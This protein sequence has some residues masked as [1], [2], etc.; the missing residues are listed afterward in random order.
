MSEKLLTTE[1][2]EKLIIQRS[3]HKKNKEF[4]K[5]DDIREFL[6]D[7]YVYVHDFEGKTTW[8]LDIP[9]ETKPL[10]PSSSPSFE[11]DWNFYSAN[12][13]N[14][15][16][17]GGNEKVEQVIFDENGLTAKEA[18]FYYETRGEIRPTSE[19]ELLKKI[20]RCKGS[21][22]FHFKILWPDGICDGDFSKEELFSSF[23]GTAPEWVHTAFNNQVIK[24]INSLKQDKRGDII[25][26][27]Y[28]E[29]IFRNNNGY[30]YK[31][32]TGWQNI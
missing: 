11:R 29:Y 31:G 2:I 23:K 20:I 14:F 16:F 32:E 26:L 21:L 13:D 28:L 19:P 4:D 6:N 27:T 7:H 9:P 24:K 25:L 1:E 22:S 18:F 12:M 5:A 30:R 8:H 17:D 15:C 10:D 3:K